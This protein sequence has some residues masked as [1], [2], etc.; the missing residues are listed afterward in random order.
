MQ[1][2]QWARVVLPNLLFRSIQLE[3]KKV[4]G[5]GG[6]RRVCEKSPVSDDEIL[7]MILLIFRG[8]MC[9]GDLLAAREAEAVWP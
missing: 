9:L 4:R 7:L 3:W 8:G 1:I 6:F 2:V 5:S